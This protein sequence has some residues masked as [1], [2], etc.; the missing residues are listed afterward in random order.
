M[1][2]PV[3]VT[4]LE[5]YRLHVRFADGVEGNLDLSKQSLADASG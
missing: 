5:G 3:H 1:F 4:P 2:R